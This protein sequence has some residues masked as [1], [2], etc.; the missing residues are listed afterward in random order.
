MSPP[1]QQ[2]PATNRRDPFTSSIFTFNIFTPLLLSRLVQF[3]FQKKTLRFFTLFFQPISFKDS[4]GHRQQLLYRACAR[5]MFW[6]LVFY[7][8]KFDEEPLKCYKISTTKL[9]VAALS[10]AAVVVAAVTVMEYVAQHANVF[11]CCCCCCNLLQFILQHFD[12]FCLYR[13]SSH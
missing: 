4:L 6:F 11:F 5:L 1:L 12:Y 9:F 3:L 13:D 8:N 2:P 7:A 10:A